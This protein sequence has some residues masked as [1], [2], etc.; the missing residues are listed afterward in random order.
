M[1]WSSVACH[2][3]S[4]AWA[5][6]YAAATARPVAERPDPMATRAERWRARMRHATATVGRAGGASTAVSASL[7]TTTMPPAPSQ[8][9]SRPAT[10]RPR[11]GHTA[12]RP[13]TGQSRPPTARPQTAASSRHETS[14]V[15]A[16]LEGRGLGR[17]VGIA[18]L[19]RDTGRVNL[20]Q[21]CAWFLRAKRI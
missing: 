15:V 10:S 4:E 9:S 16:V 7:A 18:A 21:V 2:H 5:T 14:Y 11:T 8:P 3:P 20:I 17:E 13:Y 1:P 19:D 12:S 6:L